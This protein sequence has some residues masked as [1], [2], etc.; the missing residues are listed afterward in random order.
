MME[1]G[2]L[3]EYYNE[4]IKVCDKIKNHI[5]KYLNYIKRCK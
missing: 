2:I 3:E 1:D 5:Q 4:C